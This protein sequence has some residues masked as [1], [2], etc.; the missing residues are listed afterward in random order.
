MCCPSR[1]RATIA[2]GASFSVDGSA[3]VDVGAK[4]RLD[5]SAS[6]RVTMLGNAQKSRDASMPKMERCVSEIC[7]LLARGQDMAETAFA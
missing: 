7:R 5:A 3:A 2:V 1:L 6:N 4:T